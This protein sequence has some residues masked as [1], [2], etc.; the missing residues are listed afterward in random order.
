MVRMFAL[1][2]QTGVTLAEVGFLLILFA[3]VWLVAAQIPAF[4]MPKARRSSQAL[5]SPSRARFSSSPR[6]GVTS[7]D[8]PE[9]AVGAPPRG[10]PTYI[11][12]RERSPMLGPPDLSAEALP[13][14]SPPGPAE[15][16]ARQPLNRPRLCGQ[17]GGG[18]D[19]RP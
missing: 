19:W 1:S 10:L 12:G 17:S 9:S 2:H 5:R 7:A 13:G 18:Q 11:H 3:G 15:R 8:R 14:S 4:K 16:S 6:T